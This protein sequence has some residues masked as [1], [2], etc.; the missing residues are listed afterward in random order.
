MSRRGY[1]A[2]KL[3][4]ERWPNLSNLIGCYFNQDFDLLYGSLEGAFESAVRDG[5][6]AYRQS[7][8]REWRDLQLV[9]GTGTDLRASLAVLGADVLFKKAKDARSFMNLFYD[10]L[11]EQVRAETSK[12]WKP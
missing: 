9:E 3:V 4:E 1:E 12:E 10:K 11:I 5:T 2:R 7:V 6:L 8:L